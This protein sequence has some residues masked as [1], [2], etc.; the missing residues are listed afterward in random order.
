MVTA[1]KP[2]KRKVA[3]GDDTLVEES[4]LIRQRLRNLCE[5][6]IAIGQKQG[7]LG[8]HEEIN[9]RDSEGGQDGADKG[10]IR[11]CEAAPP[12]ENK[13]GNQEGEG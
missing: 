1:V 6:A 7:L 12:G 13:A 8:N 4:L 9:T 3:V 2:D 5:L 11:G 10:N